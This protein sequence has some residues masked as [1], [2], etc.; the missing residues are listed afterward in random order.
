MKSLSDDIRLISRLFFRQC[1]PS[2][3]DWSLL[4]GL[5]MGNYR[6]QMTVLHIEADI[7]HNGQIRLS[8]TVLRNM[9]RR[10]SLQS[11]YKTNLFKPKTSGVVSVKSF[12]MLSQCF[13]DQ[14]TSILSAALL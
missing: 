11:L 6:Y 13:K 2:E 1:V 10:H 8:E 7:V 14:K 3:C 5:Q 9:T 4:L 12:N